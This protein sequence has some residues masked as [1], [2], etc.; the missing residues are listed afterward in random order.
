[1][2][3]ILNIL[4]TFL[5]YIN[6]LAVNSNDSTQGYWTS[7]NSSSEA[8]WVIRKSGV[9]TIA[10]FY[11]DYLVYGIRPVITIKKSLLS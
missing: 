7:T 1:M 8:F 10:A 5:R 11:E 4:I 3:K 6:Y 2:T 9:I